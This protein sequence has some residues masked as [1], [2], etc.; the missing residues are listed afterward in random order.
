M[1]QL[2]LSRGERVL[3]AL[4]DE[5][6]AW[7]VGTDQ[8]LHLGRAEGGF[9]RLPWE[10]IDR[11]TWDRDSERLVVVEVAD[12]GQEQSTWRVSVG[13]PARLLGLI[14]ERVT[15][16][17]LLSRHM[18]VPGSKGLKVVARRSP[19]GSGPIEWSF[20]LSPG[21]SPSDDVVRAAVERGLLEA[22]AELAL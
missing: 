8:A 1:A 22:R 4:R 15:A 5:D 16:S 9:R 18:A 17:V 11:A 14:R 21:L 19:G 12:F 10:R 3:A 13:E 7:H 2:A 6:A 20:W